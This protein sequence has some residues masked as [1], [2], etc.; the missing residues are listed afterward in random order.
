MI[1]SGR[2]A[3]L[4]WRKCALVAA[5]LAAGV[6][7]ASAAA[8]PNPKAIAQKLI[9]AQSMQTDIPNRLDA[10]DNFWGF[11]LPRSLGEAILW[12]AVIGGALAIGYALRD[13]LPG[14]DRSRRLEAEGSQGDVGL[15]RVAMLAGARNEADALAAQGRYDEAMH[16]LLLR[17]VGEL[18][19]KLRL[20]IADSLTAREIERRAPLDGSGKGAFS[21]IVRAVEH[22]VFGR[23][24]ADSSAYLACRDDFDAFAASLAGGSA[25]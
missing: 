3:M 13:N 18:R 14:W 24:P 21:R 17:A 11:H 9:A 16:V 2:G 20:S 8:A 23:E 1:E 10:P 7:G 6:V 22:A 15:A 4:R 25:P 5:A 19:E 12:I